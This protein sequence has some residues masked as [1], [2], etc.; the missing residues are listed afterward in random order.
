MLKTEMKTLCAG[1]ERK[2]VERKVAAP[3]LEAG[4]GHV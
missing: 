2:S 1:W 4:K 3:K